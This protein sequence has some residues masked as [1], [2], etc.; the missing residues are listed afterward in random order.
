[1]LD[2]VFPSDEALIE[3]MTSLDKPW[4]DLHHRSYFLLDLSRIEVREFNLTMTGDISCPI[5]PLAK[6]EV[7]VEGN[8]ETIIE[9]IP[10]NISQT[11]GIMENVFV[12]VD[13]SPREIQMYTYLFKEFRD[14]FPW[15]YEEMVGID[16]KIFKHEITTYPYAKP[17]RQKL[18]PV[19]PRKAATIKVEVEKLLKASF[20]YPIHLTQWVSNPVLINKKQ[21]MICVCKDFHDLNKACLK[22]NFPTPFIDQII[23]ECARRVAY[24]RRYVFDHIFESL[25]WIYTY[26]SPYFEVPHLYFS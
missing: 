25:V 12:G 20:I 6:H 13:C 10:I 19:N 3:A 7:Y 16:P 15:S 8:M 17:V 26:L 2:I 22:D 21:G 14:V 11:P 9:T 5:N 18:R 4:D 1:L 23:D 24:Q